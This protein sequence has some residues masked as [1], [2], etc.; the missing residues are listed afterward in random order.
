M[1]KY[2]DKS[3]NAIA[4]FNF[5]DF[6]ILPGF[7]KASPRDIPIATRFTKN[8]KMNI[9]L[10]SSPMDTVTEASMAIAI[11]KKGGIG[12]I[13]RNCTIEEEVGMVKAVK[14]GS[15]SSEECTDALLD[16]D[17]RL[18]V[19]AA[20]SPFDI[21]RAMRLAKYADAL[22]IDVAHFHNPRIIDGTR[23]IIKETG[24]DVVIGSF[25]TKEAVID[26]VTK[27]DDA[28]GLRVGIGCGSICTTTDVTRAGAPTLFAVA[29]AADALQE[30]GSDI[31]II[32]DGGIRSAGDIALGMIFGASSAMLGFG[33]AGCKESP[34]D[35]VI[36]EGKQYKRYRGMG[37]KQ[38]RAKRAA[39]DRYE[40]RG[41]RDLE[42]GVEMLIPYVG[43]IDEI[44]DKLCSGIRASIGYAGAANI[45]EMK[46]L[47]RIARVNTRESAILNKAA[48]RNAILQ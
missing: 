3:R 33:F 28:A 8:I 14:E 17:K 10:V 34:N 16:E 15:C 1:G 46:E 6:I 29:Q 9:P 44:V 23:K 45:S 41:G 43:A 26:C 22:L 38:A 11:A 32:A 47:T 24:K 13:H 40:S 37:S 2:I 20:V 25:G 5:E 42:E 19:A 48:V 4:A 12:V 7:V 30:V 36:V 21:D 27:L 39:L 31:P 18:V 35:V